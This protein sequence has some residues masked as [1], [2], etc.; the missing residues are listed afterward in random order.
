[1]YWS[2]NTYHQALYETEEMS[3]K[4]GLFLS[5]RTFCNIYYEIKQFYIKEEF[6][7]EVWEL[8]LLIVA[9]TYMVINTVS[10][11]FTIKTMNKY[12]GVMTKMLNLTE[13]I[14]D[15]SVKELYDEDL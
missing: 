1:M 6:K 13:K 10:T 12:D 14:L 9:F 5:L 3:P 15:K 4:H 7:M 2:Y 8:A 11:V